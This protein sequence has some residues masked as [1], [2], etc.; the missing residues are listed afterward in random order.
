MTTSQVIRKA[1][2]LFY[3]RRL[4]DIS[5]IEILEGHC[6]NKHWDEVI[7]RINYVVE[8]GL[9]VGELDIFDVKVRQEDTGYITVFS[10]FG[11]LSYSVSREIR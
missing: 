9:D 3:K 4:G 1:M 6:V 11:E 5:S 7:V 2:S 10:Y 8:K